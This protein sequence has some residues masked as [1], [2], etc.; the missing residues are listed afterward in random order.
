MVI[1]L[2]SEILPCLYGLFLSSRRT[3]TTKSSHIV[4]IKGTI[5]TFVDSNLVA[6]TW[7]Y[8]PYALK[9]LIFWASYLPSQDLGSGILRA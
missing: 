7:K 5:W 9:L 6:I 2:L 4:H 3:Y 8:L 1:A